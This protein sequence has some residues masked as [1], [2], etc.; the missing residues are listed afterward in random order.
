MTATPPHGTVIATYNIHYSIGLD[1]RFAPGRIAEL[2]GSF[3]ADVVALQEVGW[4]Y[5]GHA[6]VDQ[7]E[8]LGNL[9]GHTV[10]AGLTR[11]HKNAHFGNAILTR[12][13]AHDVRTLDLTARFRAP[14]CALIVELEAGPGR[15]RIV[16]VH[17]GL[18]PWERREQVTRLLAA[19]DEVD[20]LPT[21]L[22]G[23]FNDWRREPA[24]LE[25]IAK[26]FPVSAMPQSYPSRRPF[27]RYDRIYVSPPLGLTQAHALHAAPAHRASD[28]LPVI[29]TLSCPD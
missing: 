4:H 15:V 21:V 7:F 24:Y 8:L 19:L 6:S 17:F 10:H 13:P 9:T 14:R 5:R 22:L 3:N 23:D 1:R 18:D 11:K 27:L 29:A 26:R 20:P 2:I 25:P 12:L 28:H 16:N